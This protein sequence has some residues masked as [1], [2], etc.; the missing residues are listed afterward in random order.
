FA[1]TGEHDGG[2]IAPGAPA[3]LLI[4]DWERLVADIVEPDVPAIDLL[5]GRA[6]R[7]H[8]KHLFVSGK[9]VVADG[10]VISVDLATLEQ[11]LLSQL[12]AAVHSTADVRAVMPELRNA[13]RAHYG[14]PLYC[15]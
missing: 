11:E 9:K 12:R 14:E 10:K 7:E 13:I 4:L 5:L 6:R 8:I 2:N 1:V 3:D 15:V